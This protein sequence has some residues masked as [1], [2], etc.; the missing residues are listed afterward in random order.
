MAI[1]CPVSFLSGTLVTVWLEVIWASGIPE[2]E[3]LDN[4]SDVDVL[5]NSWAQRALERRTNRIIFMI[6]GMTGSWDLRVR[7]SER[8]NT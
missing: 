1:W 3:E 6:T 2:T 7:K 5:F 4:H 8:W